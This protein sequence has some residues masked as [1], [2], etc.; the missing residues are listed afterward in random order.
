MKK[1]MLF[2]SLFLFSAGCTS[3]S[4]TVDPTSSED[5]RNDEVAVLAKNL[6]VPWSI[7]KNG[8]I[9]YVS[10]RPGTIAVIKEGKAEHQDVQ[11]E[12]K[13]ADQSEAG[14]LGFVL[15]DDFDQ[16][17][18]AYAYYSYQ[19]KGQIMNRVVLLTQKEDIWEE[20]RLLLD[21]IPGG[22]T[23]DG[24]RIKIGP[25]G[26]LYITVG[27]AGNKEEA[28]NM[29]SLNGKILRMNLDGS[30]PEDNPFPQSYIYSLG[31]R[32]PQGLAWS[33]EGVLYASEHGNKAND[34]INKIE[35]RKNYGWP[36][37]Q[38]KEERSEME[39]PLFTSGN[40][41]TWAPSGMEFFN[42]QLYVAALRGSAIVKFDLKSGNTEKMANQFGRIR[43]VYIE[44]GVL[45][46]VSNNTDGR[47]SPGKEDDK[48]YR[49]ALP[50]S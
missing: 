43:D 15:T 5:N 28:Q 16:T 23:H 36:L 42:E 33:E 48:L 18:E 44:N 26:K 1:I 27:D 19:T 31:H 4:S 13:L 41:E 10:E 6:H 32:N 45:Y 49:L 40:N 17:K 20:S 2:I 35:P 37:I 47:G 25:D 14:F 39:S 24:G 29:S 8:D 34:E 11:F 22:G 9:F 50:E 3:N 12:E 7:Q 30:I 21:N 46:F 38:G